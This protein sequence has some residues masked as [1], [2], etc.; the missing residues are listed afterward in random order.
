MNTRLDTLTMDVSTLVATVTLLN[1]ADESVKHIIETKLDSLSEDHPQSLSD[2][3]LSM[4]WPTDFNHKYKFR[5]DPELL[6]ENTHSLLTKSVW[7]WDIMDWVDT[8]TLIEKWNTIRQ[9]RDQLLSKCDW[10]QLPDTSLVNKQAWIT[11]RQAL[12]DITLQPDPL[13]ITWPTLL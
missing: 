13:N 9:E 12:R 4:D 2:T 11:Y 8:R 10:T 3:L 1:I 5:V 6:I 7:D